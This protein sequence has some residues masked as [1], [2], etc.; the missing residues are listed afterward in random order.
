ME[1]VLRPIGHPLSYDNNGR[2]A[3]ETY[4][5]SLY[6]CCL[7][8]IAYYAYDVANRLTGVTECLGNGCASG[9][10]TVETL[11]Y[12]ALNRRASVTRPNGV[13]STYGYDGAGRLTALAHGG[14]TPSLDFLQTLSYGPSGQLLT[15]GQASSAYIWS[16]QPTTTAN[17]THDQLKPR[18]SHGGG[19]AD[20]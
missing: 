8:D 3:S 19:V 10:L 13:A 4:S 7:S 9:S 11:T 2:L 16:G 17:F 14:P 6:N 5:T 12:G 1:R 20:L 15:Q 18:R